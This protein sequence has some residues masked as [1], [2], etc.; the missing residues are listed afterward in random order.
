MK[1]KIVADSSINHVPSSPVPFASVPLRIIA[2]EHEFVDDTSFR[3]DKMEQA[4][5]SCSKSGTA[6]PGLEDWLNAFEDAEIIFCITITSA[7]S[8]TYSSACLAKA[9]YEEQFPS[10]HV[11]VL[12][13]LSTGPE[14]LLIVEKLQSLILSGSREDD[15][16]S[17]IHRYIQHTHLI[18]SLESLQNLANNGRVSHTTAKLAGILGI[19]AVGQASAIG[20]FQLLS[21]ARGQQRAL[22]SIMKHMRDNGYCGGKVR[23]AHNRNLI[24]A[25]ALAALLL[26]A[27]PSADICIGVTGALC[28]YYAET[29][30]LMVGYEGAC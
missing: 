14:M 10:R 2:G 20:E 15:I 1:Y 6:C 28:C 4:L 29:G 30:G 5:A 22:S 24:A 26:D 13:S 7:L 19:R 9:E 18:F 25:K 8:G 21:K 27:H 16:L 12:D 23:I 17:E 11:H 3:S